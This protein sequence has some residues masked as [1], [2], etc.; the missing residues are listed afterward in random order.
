MAQQYR[1]GPVTM[2]DRGEDDSP[3]K[4]ERWRSRG[5]FGYSRPDW[6]RGALALDCTLGR[7]VRGLAPAAKDTC[8]F[9]A[10]IL[11]TLYAR[12]D[13]TEETLGAAV[14]DA[15]LNEFFRSLRDRYDTVVGER[16]HRRYE[17][18]AQDGLYATVYQRQFR[19]IAG[20]TAS[21]VEPTR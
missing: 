17:L 11:G 8:W 13:A 10:S 3:P 7:S 16:G 20:L 1:G 5:V 15:H 12:P 18:V 6:R 14:R 19:G 21:G 4:L 2:I 9:H